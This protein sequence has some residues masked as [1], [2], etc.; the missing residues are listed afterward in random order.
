MQMLYVPML[1]DDFYINPLDW[2]S[3]N[4]LSL[5]LRSRAYI[6]SART[7]E[8]SVLCDLSESGHSVTSVAWNEQVSHN[9]ILLFLC[10]IV[11]CG[12]L[13]F[14]YDIAYVLSLVQV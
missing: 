7:E 4:I 14:E 12:S 8:V 13:K 11:N 3:Q 1:A 2:S 5:G 9:S 10:R 6:W